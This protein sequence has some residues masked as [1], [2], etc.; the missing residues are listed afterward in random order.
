MRIILASKSPRRRELLGGV[1]ESFD[2]ITVPTD[3]TL[4]HGTELSC[5]VRELAE[6][7]GNAVREYL[8]REGVS[9]DDTM[10]ISADT[11]VDLGGEALGKPEST[12]D[13]K[14]M[15]RALSGSE[16]FVHT[17]IAVSLGERLSSATDTTRVFFRSL[18]DEE[19]EAYIESGEPMDKAGA[20]AIQGLGGAFVEKIE[21][22]FDTVVGLS[23]DL[24][25][26]LIGKLQDLG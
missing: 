24:L 8:L 1:F 6:R 19:I 17:G 14:R 25:K 12:E 18:T 4:P 23:V 5:G 16:H 21:G 20:Y 10:I 13:A 7:K 22:N 9:L 3:E 15:L 2:I 26:K 11:L